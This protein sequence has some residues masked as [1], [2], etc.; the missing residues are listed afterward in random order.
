MVKKPEK[1]E[2]TVEKTV[3][4][5]KEKKNSMQD[6]TKSKPYFLVMK[7]M[8]L[9]FV[10]NNFIRELV[11]AVSIGIVDGELR[12][13]LNQEQDKKLKAILTSEQYEKWQKARTQARPC[14]CS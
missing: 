11:A 6:Y 9:K 4:D 8:L 12:I 10:K 2:S 1:K 7:Q 13:D 3:E 5:K 14:A